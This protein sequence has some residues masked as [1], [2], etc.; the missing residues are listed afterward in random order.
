MLLLIKII[1]VSVL[2][3][4]LQQQQQQLTWL[5]QFACKSNMQAVHLYI[6]LCWRSFRIPVKKESA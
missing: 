3:I 6:K 5:D 4:M 1:H 2:K